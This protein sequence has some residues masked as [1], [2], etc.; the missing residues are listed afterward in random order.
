MNNAR[1]HSLFAAAG[2]L[3]ALA[4]ATRISSAPLALDLFGA[5]AFLPV[6][7]W[8]LHTWGRPGEF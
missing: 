7:E 5:T 2:L 1:K 4:V 3:L 8:S 6:R